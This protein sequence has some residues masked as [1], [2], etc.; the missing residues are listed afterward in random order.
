MNTQF[1]LK[2]RKSEEESKPVK[3]CL[4]SSKNTNLFT[5]GRKFKLHF[6][7]KISQKEILT[8]KLRSKSKV[9]FLKLRYF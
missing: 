7:D 2:I 4:A 6:I 9:V 8:V 1:K 5:I 3:I